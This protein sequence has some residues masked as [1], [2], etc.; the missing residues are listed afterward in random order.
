MMNV[1]SMS[2]SEFLITQYPVMLSSGPLK[3]GAEKEALRCPPAP[4]CLEGLVRIFFWSE[5]C[6]VTLLCG[7]SIMPREFPL[8]TDKHI[9]YSVFQTL[10]HLQPCPRPWAGG[11]G[12]EDSWNQLDSVFVLRLFVSLS[13]CLC[14]CLSLCWDSGTRRLRHWTS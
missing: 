6:L 1:Q 2:D 12:W 10:D 13:L 3:Q 7:L 14:L 5:A 11:G 8:C 4:W 9:C